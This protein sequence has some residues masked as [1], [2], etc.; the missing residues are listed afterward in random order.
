MG[1]VVEIGDGK[2]L[3]LGE[4]V[5]PHPLQGPGAD[6]Y[7]HLGLEDAKGQRDDIE[8][9]HRTHY[10]AKHIHGLVRSV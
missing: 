1:R 10:Y 8:D 4:H 6:P 3:Q 7:H 5:I 2:I 9:D